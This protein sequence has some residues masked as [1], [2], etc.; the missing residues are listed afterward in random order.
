MALTCLARS[1][2]AL[3]G[4][5]SEGLNATVEEFIII[6]AKVAM[7]DRPKVRAMVGLVG[8]LTG[9]ISATERT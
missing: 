9:M 6:P 8:D 1:H 5:V 2:M 3:I 4:T 7:A